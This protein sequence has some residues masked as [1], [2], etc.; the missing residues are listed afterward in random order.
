[1][2]GDEMKT[3]RWV[4][5]ILLCAAAVV[6]LQAVHVRTSAGQEKVVTPDDPRYVEKMTGEQLAVALA[7]GYQEKARLCLRFAAERMREMET[8]AARAQSRNRFRHVKALARAWEVLVFDGAVKTARQGS[9]QRRDMTES[10]RRIQRHLTGA[11]ERFGKLLEKGMPQDVGRDLEA[12]RERARSSAMQAAADLRTEQ[13]RVERHR[14]ML[15]GAEKALREELRKGGMNEAQSAEIAARIRSRCR[16][17]ERVHAQLAAEA[18]LLARRK[19]KEADALRFAASANRLADAGVEP[20]QVRQTARLLLG[21]DSSARWAQRICTEMRLAL[22][23]T[24]ESQRRETTHRLGIVLGEALRLG[25]APEAVAEMFRALNR[26]RREGVPAGLL[27]DFLGREL[28]SGK[29]VPA[30]LE[31]EL[32][33]SLETVQRLRRAMEQKARQYRDG[34]R[35]QSRHAKGRKTQPGKS[36]N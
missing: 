12:A 33:K 6:A 36:G 5:R 22:E 9:A 25:L 13:G 16:Y 30:G 28:K 31:G 35:S 19:A 18:M 14:A 17:H 3:Q 29:T 15:E 23:E 21:A 24:G 27:L 10:F 2:K 26:V 11:A 34:F 8:L 1:M 7:E 32:K 20:E 4:R